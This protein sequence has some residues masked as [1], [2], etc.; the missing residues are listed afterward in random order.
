MVGHHAVGHA[1][2]AT[3]RPRRTSRRTSTSP[4]NSD[5]RVLTWS[6]FDHAAT[7]LAAQLCRLGVAPGD[8]VAV[9]HKRQRR[10]PRPARRR[11]NAAARSRW[12]SGRAPG[13]GKSRRSCGPRVP[14]L[15]VSDLRTPPAGGAGGRRRRSSAACRGA[16]RRI[17]A[18]VPRQHAHGRVHRRAVARGTRR[19]LPDQLDLGHHWAAQMRRAH[20][21]PLAL[22]SPE[23]GRQRRTDRRR[24]LPAGHP[25]TVR[26]RHLDLAHHT[27]LPGRHGG[28]DRTFRSGGDLRRHRASP[29]DGVVLRQHATDDAAGERRIARLRPDQPARRVHRR[30]AAALHAGSTVRGAHR[31]HDPAVLRLQ[32]D[33]DAERDHH[34]GHRCI[35]GCGPRGRSCPK[36]R[37]DCSTGTTTSPNP[38]ADSRSAAVRR[39]SLGYLGG[40]DHDKLFTKDG[41]MR[42][43]DICEL[44]SDGYLSLA[45]RTSD[46][47][48][49]GGKNISAVA[50]E[51]VVA[52]HPAVAVAAAVAMPDPVFG[53][54]VCAFVELKRGGDT[55]P[56]HAGRA[57]ARAGCLQGAAA[58]T[59]RSARRAAAVLRRQDRQR[60]TSRRISDR[61]SS[62]S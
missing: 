14:A 19:R 31:G 43:G 6:E 52:T 18:P 48:L 41:W 51:E 27:H 1:F 47:I 30:R 40:T 5:D 20:P 13:Y 60:P 24:R 54:R 46:F 33:R 50:V 29:R 57:P 55:R 36:C 59:T 4:S 25:H 42:M 34:Q 17:R 39:R 23:G 8:G 37:C 3:P 28:D 32:R 10:H 35:A 49:R 62:R 22:L 21:E 26:L 15:V 53:E 2:A 11:S 9:W 38:V 12:G 7:N 61:H 56:A 16:R 45:G 44:D 58:R